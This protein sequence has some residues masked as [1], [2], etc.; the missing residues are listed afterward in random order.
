MVVVV[1]VAGED[2]GGKCGREH[3]EVRVCL[4]AC[5]L[6][7][8]NEWLLVVLYILT[9]HISENLWFKIGRQIPSLHYP[10]PN[11]HFYMCCLN[12]LHVYT[13]LWLGTKKVR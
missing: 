1:E 7:E 11:T 12:V 3:S 8:G 5:F 2:K 4:E 10:Q 6:V 13:L 9:K